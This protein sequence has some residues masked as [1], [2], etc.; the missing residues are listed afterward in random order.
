MA[1]GLATLKILEDT[2]VYQRIDRMGA[3]MREGLN[4][5]MQRAG[6]EFQTTGIG[7]IFGCHF[8]RTPVKDA[9]AADSGDKEL[10]KRLMYSLL[11]KG[12]FC[13]TP[14]L[15]HCAISTAHTEAEM[16]R[17]LRVAELFAKQV[18]K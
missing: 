13:L 6:L 7:S 14:E 8:T 5:I 4:D 17:F 9:T 12:I 1:A 18:K 2:S 11:D 10:S 3:K 15:V 16:D